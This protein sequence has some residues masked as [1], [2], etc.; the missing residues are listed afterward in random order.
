[1]IGVNLPTVGGPPIGLPLAEV[2]VRPGVVSY[3]TL[4]EAVQAGNTV[5]QGSDVAV[6]PMGDPVTNQLAPPVAGG[7]QLE[8]RVVVLPGQP[9]PV[10]QSPWVNLP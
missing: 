1:M 7:L 2:L 4:P 3:A 8:L 5:I 9:V 6:A 10:P